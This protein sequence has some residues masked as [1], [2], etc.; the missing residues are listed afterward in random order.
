MTVTFF[1]NLHY[2]AYPYVPAGLQ[3][4]TVKRLYSYPVCFLAWAEKLA[5]WNNNYHGAETNTTTFW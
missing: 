3:A 2:F 5:S 1:P 4:H